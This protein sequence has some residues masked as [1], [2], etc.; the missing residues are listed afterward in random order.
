VIGPSTIG[1]SLTIVY[2]EFSNNSFGVEVSSGAAVVLRNV[3]VI[4]A[5]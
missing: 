4:N 5:L 3:V 2:S 1:A